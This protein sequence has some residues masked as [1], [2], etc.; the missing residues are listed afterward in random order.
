[1]IGT[2]WNNIRTPV[3]GV[4]IIL[5]SGQTQVKQQTID[6]QTVYNRGELVGILIETLNKIAAPGASKDLTVYYAFSNNENRVP[7]E[8]ATAAASQ[9]CTLANVAGARRTYSLPISYQGG[10]YLHIWFTTVAFTDVSAQ[11]ELDVSVLAKT[12][13]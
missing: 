2:F 6:L 12:M 7:D 11:V 10:R 4:Q 9:A 8:L 5:G 13:N 3:P 1:M